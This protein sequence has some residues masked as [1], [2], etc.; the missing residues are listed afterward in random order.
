MDLDQEEFDDLI[1]K[2]IYKQL[3]NQSFELNCCGLCSSRPHCVM[4]SP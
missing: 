3:E 2:V 4:E 1:Q